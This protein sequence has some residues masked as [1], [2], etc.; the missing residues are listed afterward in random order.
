MRCGCEQGI[1]ISCGQGKEDILVADLMSDHVVTAHLV[2]IARLF[3]ES[4][5]GVVPIM[6][7]SN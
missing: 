7:K 5:I 1:C 4:R 6:E 2:T 3:V